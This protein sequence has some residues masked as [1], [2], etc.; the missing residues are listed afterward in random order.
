MPPH[1]IEEESSKKWKKDEW[2]SFPPEWLKDN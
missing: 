2:K 1:L